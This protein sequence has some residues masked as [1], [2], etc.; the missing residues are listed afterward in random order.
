VGDNVI[1]VFPDL[2]KEINAKI[3][4]ASRYISPANRTFTVEVRLAPEKNGFKANMIAILKIND[5]KADKALVIPINYIQ[6]DPKGNFVYIVKMKGSKNI[7]T[8]AFISEGQSY[9]GMIE[10][11]KGLQPEDK[12]ITSNY[13][14]L[15]EG[16]NIT[17]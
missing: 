3:T 9:N 15:E 1:A 6:S 12:I 17:F 10:V 13:L 2:N 14:E 16:E 7:A 11:T 4:T 8:K 5:Y